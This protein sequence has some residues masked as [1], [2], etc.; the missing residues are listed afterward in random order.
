MVAIDLTKLQQQIAALAEVYAEPAAFSKAFHALLSFYQRYAFRPNR[1]GIPKTF[2]RSYSLP[3]QVLPQIEIGLRMTA[4]ERPEETL[5]LVKALWQEPYFESHDLAAYLLGQLPPNK[6]SEVYA[7]LRDWLSESVDHG[8]LE[9]LFSKALQPLQQAGQWKPFLKELLASPEVRTQ[10]YGLLGLARTAS[11]FPLVELPELLN[12][13]KPFLVK[14]DNK[15]EASLSQAIEALA[16]RSPYETAY[17]LKLVLVETPGSA[18]ER[19]MRTYVPFFPEET[20]QSLTDAIKTHARLRELE[21]S[22]SP[23]SN[24]KSPRQ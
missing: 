19:R 17:L 1:K 13:I 5:A 20:A 23:P 24:E 2:L 10:G 22:I 11:D 12:E 8:A 14:F 15:L 4:R 21:A 18:I 16:Q 9:A 7:I 6:A 3:L